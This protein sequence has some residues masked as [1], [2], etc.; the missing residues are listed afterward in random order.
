MKQICHMA[1]CN[2]VSIICQDLE[3][4]S[5]TFKEKFYDLAIFSMKDPNGLPNLKLKDTMR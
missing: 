4:S 3:S 2:I 1:Q 5:G